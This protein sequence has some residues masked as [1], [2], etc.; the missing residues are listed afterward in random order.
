MKN[1]QN[2]R[3]Y[4]CEV[5]FETKNNDDGELAIIPKEDFMVGEVL[6]KAGT[7]LLDGIL[8]AGIDFH[9]YK[10]RD[11]AFE[12]DSNGE[13]KMPLNLIG[14]FAPKNIKDQHDSSEK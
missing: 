8:E 9:L 5:F 11:L 4:P 10:N 13:Y 14:F 2:Y 6:I 12:I 1:M 3:R 7:E